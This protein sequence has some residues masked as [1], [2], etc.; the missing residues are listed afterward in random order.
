MVS[1][2]QEHMLYYSLNTPRKTEETSF[3]P[4]MSRENLKPKG[5]NLGWC[6]F[7]A[8]TLPSS[9]FWSIRGCANRTL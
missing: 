2:Q 9:L 3:S 1:I 6:T 7:S 8:S 5:M 4:I